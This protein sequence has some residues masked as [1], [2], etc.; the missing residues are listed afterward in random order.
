ML[1]IPGGQP[2]LEKIPFV[3]FLSCPHFASGL[4]GTHYETDRRNWCVRGK[5]GQF[6]E[7][8]TDKYRRFALYIAGAKG[9]A[10]D[11]HNLPGFDGV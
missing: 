3:P 4:L 1:K 11:A 7:V 6:P 8:G 5:S 10:A 9:S 2:V